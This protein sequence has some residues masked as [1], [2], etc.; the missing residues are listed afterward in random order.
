[1]SD[2]RPARSQEEPPR[3]AQG[4]VPSVP[5]GTSRR[6]PPRPP[7]GLAVKALPEATVGTYHMVT[8]MWPAAKPLPQ[9]TPAKSAAPV[10]QVRPAAFCCTEEDVLRRRIGELRLRGRGLS[11]RRCPGDI[12]RG[13]VCHG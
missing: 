9:R 6:D 11:R 1:M 7:G 12:C 8:W 13:V 3:F 10:P 2:D 4:D 5:G